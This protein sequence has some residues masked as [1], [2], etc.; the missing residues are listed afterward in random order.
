[1]EHNDND[2]LEKIV[3]VEKRADDFG[4]SWETLEQ[5]LDQIKSECREVQEASLSNNQK[6]LQEEIGDLIYAA[7]SLSIFC[8]FDPRKTLHESIQKFEKRFQT[9]VEIAKSDGL[10]SFKGLP[11]TTLLAYWERAK[12][13]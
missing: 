1:M 13:A 10:D 6:H 8:D 5:I 9:M 3:A 11:L 4:F 2:L 12:R 7:I